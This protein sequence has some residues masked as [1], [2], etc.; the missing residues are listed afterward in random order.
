ME[1]M[2]IIIDPGPGSLVRALDQGLHPQK[3]DA[4][5]VTHNHLDH[6]NDAEVMIEAMTHGMRSSKGLFGCQ[7]DVVEYISDYHLNKAEHLVLEAGKGFDIGHVN[8]KPIP[9]KDH[10]DGLGL[11]MTVGDRTV[12]YSSDTDYGSELIEH[13]TD[14]DILILNTLFP[15]GDPS[16]THLCTDDAIK[17]ADAARP[18][19][20]V[21]THFGV[22]ML[23]ED[24]VV[25]A[26]MVQDKT[27]VDTMAAYDGL[28]IEVE[29]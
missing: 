21:L 6:Y 9:T 17:I 15:S 28:R 29:E 7:K 20:L 22:R 12:T 14:S 4:V 25:Q 24:P 26:R 5:L 2:R 18:K 19:L 23:N 13:Y 27:G 8:C 3:L 16:P 1:D 11:R 10:V